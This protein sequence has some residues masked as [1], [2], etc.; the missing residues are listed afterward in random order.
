[1]PNSIDITP[2]E[3]SQSDPA[4]VREIADLIVSAL[5]LDIQA[6]EIDPAAPLYG[7]GLGLDSIDILEIAL[8]ASKRYGLKLKDDDRDNVRVFASLNSLA[9]HVAE[10]RTK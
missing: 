6:D 7:E 10:R 3:G 5:N 2:V 9:S 1:M 4:L 8:V